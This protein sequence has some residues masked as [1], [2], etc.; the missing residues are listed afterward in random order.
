MHMGGDFNLPL[1]VFYVSL[2]A[3]YGFFGVNLFPMEGLTANASFRYNDNF[4]AGFSP[5]DRTD[6]AHKGKDVYKLPS[7]SLIDVDLSYK[8][9]L[10]GTDCILRAHVLNAL[11]T[12]YITYGEDQGFEDDNTNSLPKVFYGFGMQMRMSLKV[13]I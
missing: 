11:Y 8:L 12:E 10:M 1:V 2:L 5:T 9:N 3:C 4:Y 13:N 7:Y 6:E